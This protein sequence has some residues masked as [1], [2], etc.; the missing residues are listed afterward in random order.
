MTQSQIPIR[1]Y[2]SEFILSLLNMKKLLFFSFF[3]IA[4]TISDGQNFKWAKHIGGAGTSQALAITADNNGN[5]YSTGFTN[6]TAFFDLPAT[7]P[8]IPPITGGQYSYISKS[9]T[10]GNYVWLKQL[11]GASGDFPLS[12]AVDNAGNVYSCGFFTDTTDFDPGLGVYNLGST[13][14]YTSNAYISKLDASGNFV[15][16]KKIGDGEN[17]AFSIAVEPSS[18]IV[19]LTGKFSGTCDFDPG[20]GVVNI[21]SAGSEDIFL[22][23]LDVAGNFMWAKSIGSTG[24][25]RGNALVIDPAGFI[26]A[27]G[28]FQNTVDFDPGA[29]T[30]SFVSAGS[31]DAFTAKF[32]TAGNFIWAKHI[33]GNFEEYGNAITTDDSSNYYVTGLYN[34]T[35]N[36]DPGATNYTLT[37]LGYEDVFI[38]KY[39]PAGNFVWLKN[40]GGTGSDYPNSIVYGSSSIY[41]A[42]YFSNYV[43]FDPGLGVS[44]LFSAGMGDAFT[45]KLDPS[46]NLIWARRTGGAYEDYGMGIATDPFN[47]VYTTGFFEFTSDAN[48]EESDTLNFVSAGSQDV[49]L[50]RMSQDQCSNMALVLDSYHNISCI[51]PGNAVVHAIGGL[52]PYI[53][54][55]DTSPVTI[56]SAVVFYNSGIYQLTATSVNAC[57][58]TL[59]LLV[60][61]PSLVPGF[62][63]NSN[64]VTQGFRPGFSANVWIDAYNNN[65]G[66]ATGMLKIVYDTSLV[67][68]NFT[69]PIADSIIG[70]TLIW[71]FTNLT[72]DSLHLQPLINFQTRTTAVIGDTMN[73]KTIITPI[74]GDIDSTNNIKDYFFDI[75]NGFDPNEKAVYPTGICT[76]GYIPNDQLLTYTVRFQNT[77]NASA[78]NIFVIDTLDTDLLLNSVRVT[79]SSD[80]VITEVLPGNVLKFRFDAINLPD[81]MSNEPQSHGYIIFEVKPNASLLNGTTIHN[82]AEIYFDFNP[83]VYTNAVVNTINDGVTNT[84]TSISGI[85]ITANLSGTNYQWLDCNNGDTLITG[86]TSQSFTPTTNGNY[87]VIVSNGCFSDTSAC[88]AITTI[89]INELSNPSIS[90]Y[91]NP[92]NSNVIITTTK[93]TIIKIINLLGE[94]ILTKR[95]ETK[96]EIDIHSLSSGIYYLQIEEGTTYKFI[97]Q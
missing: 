92:A 64:L 50:L 84:S 24:L 38:A 70:D 89:G 20:A 85:T 81:S 82:N 96:M 65:C 41:I 74:S 26:V 66:P 39:D 97:K 91:P 28:R 95:I 18:G 45:M 35:T 56:D 67:D 71:N 53:Y 46:G 33:G 57:V 73:I 77:G 14:Y 22:L 44:P 31:D 75:I 48:P 63:L 6:D 54:S 40:I 88:V 5:V 13:N 8:F 86:A 16:A 30:T 12:I 90:I 68:I 79:G 2:E 43:D 25:D 32:D 10:N 27:T 19:Y 51:N 61:A 80:T 94:V 69:L 23:K 29:G 52:D 1:F 47:N 11:G 72:F 60:N 4:H 49:F 37:T 42:G 21:V 59:S 34:G 78:I 17:Y 87:A 55:W 76:A 15:W 7:T 83:P 62:E 36:F 3:I 93:P 58:K 9:D